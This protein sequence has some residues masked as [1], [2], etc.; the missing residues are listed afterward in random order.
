MLLKAF[1]QIILQLLGADGRNHYTPLMVGGKPYQTR[2]E[3]QPMTFFSHLQVPGQVL[4]PMEHLNM[5][6]SMVP[7]T[8]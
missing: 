2:Q 5:L 7:Y 4:L 8:D 6:Y 1:T 3:L